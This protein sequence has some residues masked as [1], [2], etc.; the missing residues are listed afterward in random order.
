MSTGLD[1]V[2]W[3]CVV[4]AERPGG[5][6]M[7]GVGGPPGGCFVREEGGRCHGEVRR[8]GGVKVLLVVRLVQTLACVDSNCFVYFLALTHNTSQAREMGEGGSCCRK[9]EASKFV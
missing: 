6:V 7:V 1:H 3:W 2:D 4:G 9:L 5:G 8:L